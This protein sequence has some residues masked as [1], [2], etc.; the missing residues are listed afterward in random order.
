M[1]ISVPEAAL[2]LGK[3]QAT[4]RRLL[5]G[6]Q[7]AGQKVG[8][9]WIVHAEK[10][11]HLPSVSTAAGADR[12]RIDVRLALRQL[13]RTD[14]RDLWV[15]DVLKWEDY[16][17]EPS[18]VLAAA[19]AKCSTGQS[20][21]VIVVNIPKG[22]HL[23]R[24]GSLLSL[25]D[26]IAYHALCA[27]FAEKAERRLSD[28]VYSSRL[29]ANQR[30]G[31]FKSGIDQWKKFNE[32]TNR[33]VRTAGP[34]M[35]KTDLVSYFETISHKVL[36]EELTLLQVPEDIKRPLRELLRG[37]RFE[38]QHG[39]PIGP[40]ASRLL[41]NIFMMRVDETMLDEGWNYWRYMDD[42][43]IIANS[44]REV[45]R[46]LRRLE[47][48]CRTRGLLLSSPKTKVGEY[49]MGEAT[50]DDSLDLAD[51][52]FRNGLDEA[53]KAI[54]KILHSSLLDKSIKTRHA[55]F[56]LVR[57][58]ALVDRAVLAKILRRLDRLKEASPESALYLRSFISETA[59]QQEITAYLA[60]P[61]EPG[62]EEYQQAWL[63]AAMLEVLGD[64]PR[65]WIIYA[66]RITQDAN[67]P[68]Y[69]RNLAANLVALGKDPEHLAWLRKT[70]I[71]NYNPALVRGTLVALARAGELRQPI[72]DSAVSRHTQLRCTAEYLRSRASLPSLIQVGLWSRVRE[73]SN[74]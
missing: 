29:N 59:L 50:D 53:R 32:T 41:G 24:A 69:L 43:R 70:A 21:E 3:S 9:R 39:I 60:G 45:V 23:S 15:P 34:W 52:F 13:R 11:P 38:T 36:F 47:V 20:D 5:A 10:L 22:P 51:Y 37:W 55:R 67:N 31:L 64:P 71:E 35:A 7:I 4:I 27:T 30:A 56:A 12:P 42:I 65:E 25:E 46:A 44:E 63:L 49:P 57:L 19:Q 6:G 8:G 66:W 2:R 48:L 16:A 14:I 17:Q 68:S 61:G 18:E 72:V 54:R 73:V 58:G 33:E 28:R 40:D 74:T 62:V 26:R 1:N